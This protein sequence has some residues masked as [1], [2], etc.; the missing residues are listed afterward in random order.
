[1]MTIQRV[2]RQRLKQA[3]TA[4]ITTPALQRF[5]MTFPYG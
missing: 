2:D 3:N 4:L 5:K 1:M